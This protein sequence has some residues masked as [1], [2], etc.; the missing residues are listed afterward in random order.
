MS[1]PTKP[2]PNSR[3]RLRRE[4]IMRGEKQLEFDKPEPTQAERVNKIVE[5]GIDEN[6][7]VDWFRK[8]VASELAAVRREGFNK[9]VD[10]SCH[11]LSAVIMGL[12][13]ATDKDGFIEEC[14][15][16]QRTKAVVRPFVP[17]DGGKAMSET[18]TCPF[19]GDGDYDLYGLKQHLTGVGYMFASPCEAFTE[20]KEQSQ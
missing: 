18:I 20:L 3:S 19:C 13:A 11:A 15:K 9:G 2:E 14:R 16:Q 12:Q 1:E 7:N 10:T 17:N 4:A 6:V 8:F 5:L